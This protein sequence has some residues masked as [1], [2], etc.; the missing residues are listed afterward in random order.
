MDDAEPSG[1]DVHLECAPR[2]FHEL[3]QL[4][5]RQELERVRF[6]PLVTPR[7]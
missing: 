1:G 4:R 2:P 7:G 6:V 5:E 3:A